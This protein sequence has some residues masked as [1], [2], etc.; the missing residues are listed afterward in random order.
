MDKSLKLKWILGFSLTGEMEFAV[1]VG[2]GASKITKRVQKGQLFTCFD[3][4]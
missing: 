4:G 3:V 1:H 2:V